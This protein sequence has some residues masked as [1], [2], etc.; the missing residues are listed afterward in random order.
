MF[1]LLLLLGFTI[2]LRFFVTTF[3]RT[4][5]KCTYKLIKLMTNSISA[6]KIF[7]KNVL[8]VTIELKCLTDVFIFGLPVG[9]QSDCFRYSTSIQSV[10]LWLPSRT[11][12]IPLP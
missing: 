11:D 9:E 7:Y 1:L 12:Q 5:A 10:V 6:S 3:Q 2:F 8:V 4:L